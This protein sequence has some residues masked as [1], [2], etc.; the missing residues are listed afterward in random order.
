MQI[1]STEQIYIFF[2]FIINGI[3]IGI[4]F[5]VFRI[6]R[7]S[8]K[9]SD[10][11]TYIEDSIFWILTGIL[12]LYSIFTFNQGEIR[13]YI[14]LALIIGIIIYILTL[15]KYFIRISIKVINLIQHILKI[16]FHFLLFPFKWIFNLLKKYFIQPIMFVFI[17][18]KK[19]N[20]K[21]LRKRQEKWNKCKKIKRTGKNSIQKKDF[22]I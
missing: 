9:T 14:F 1:N 5:D 2:I 12:I 18:L 11:I 4:F 15:S 8:F 20:Q 19:I 7:K 10:I 17:N 3:L 22:N 6:L 16:F 21:I 13:T